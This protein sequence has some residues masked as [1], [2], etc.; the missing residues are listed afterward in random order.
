MV[1]RNLLLRPVK[2]QSVAI[3]PC[4]LSVS[5]QN[6]LSIKTSI[7]SDRHTNG[8]EC[9]YGVENGPVY[10]FRSIKGQ[11]SVSAPL[12][13]LEL[14]EGEA[15]SDRQP[16]HPTCRYTDLRPRCPNQVGTNWDVHT[17]GA[18]SILLE[19]CAAHL[20]LLR[21][22]KGKLP[23]VLGGIIELEPELIS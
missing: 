11:S 23:F 19:G 4:L 10:D 22:G 5:G 2:V 14:N 1:P 7:L 6:P 15:E 8:L 17:S 12:V 13:L 3:A 18:T 20:H 9:W 16:T 21:T